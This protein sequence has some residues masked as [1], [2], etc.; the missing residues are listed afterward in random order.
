MSERED[1]LQAVRSW[2]K[3]RADSSALTDSQVIPSDDEGGRPA[4]PYMTVL[5]AV[6]GIRI[7]RD[8]TIYG[9]DG[10]DNPTYRV[11]GERKGS[12]TLHGFGSDSEEW[13]EALILAVHDPEAVADLHASGIVLGAP[14]AG[15]RDLPRMMNANREQH[16]V[17]EF[18]VTYR[19]VGPTRTSPAFDTPPVELTEISS[20]EPDS[21][22]LDF[23]V[24]TP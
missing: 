11:Q 1:I 23:S 20:T 4:L 3:A 12:V 13:L 24:E 18:P 15:V 21:L 6:S 5:V 22:P 10:G 8:E 9:V 16:Y 2:A 17:A 19:V 14:V 7:G